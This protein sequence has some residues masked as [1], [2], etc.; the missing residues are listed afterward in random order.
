MRNA[1]EPSPTAPH[2]EKRHQRRP[3]LGCLIALF[4]VALLAGIV[5]VLLVTTTG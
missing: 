4:V 3:M 5:V 2:Q 1:P